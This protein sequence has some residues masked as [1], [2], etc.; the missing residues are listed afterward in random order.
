M[1]FECRVVG[2]RAVVITPL[3]ALTAADDSRTLLVCFPPADTAV[4][5]A[6]LGPTL[7]MATLFALFAT[8]ARGT[9]A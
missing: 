6:L 1:S 4:S 3:H 8:I 2:T 9:P 5:H 7:L